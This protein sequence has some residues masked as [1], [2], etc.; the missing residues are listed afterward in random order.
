[1]PSKTPQPPPAG[2]VPGRGPF[3]PPPPPIAPSVTR[4][5]EGDTKG[6]ANGSDG[7]LIQLLPIGSEV[8]IGP[9][10]DPIKATIIGASLSGTENSIQ[11]HA[12]WW[13]GTERKS[14]WLP[15]CEVRPKDSQTTR[16]GFWHR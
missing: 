7:K 4:M 5:L 16:I 9:S 13:A 2:H 6:R 15:S 8:E 3:S 11:Y 1:M 10:T 14:E 12:S